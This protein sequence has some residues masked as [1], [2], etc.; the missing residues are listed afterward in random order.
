MLSA[1]DKA[2]DAAVSVRA[3][4]S[5]TALLEDSWRAELRRQRE[6]VAAL[7]SRC[8]TQDASL[9]SMDEHIAGQV[10]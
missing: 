1:S 3:H 5:R 10:A 8:E 4:E 2:Q 6:A 7:E 9:R